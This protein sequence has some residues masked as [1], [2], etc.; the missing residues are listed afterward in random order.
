[1]NPI[2]LIKT[3]DLEKTSDMEILLDALQIE[4]ILLNL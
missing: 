1:M 4:G 3:L 2:E